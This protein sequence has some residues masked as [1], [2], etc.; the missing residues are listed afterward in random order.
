MWIW[1]ILGNSLH[2]VTCPLDAV[3]LGHF[4]TYVLRVPNTAC[5]VM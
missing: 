2:A 3:Q 1:R 4:Y 5:I